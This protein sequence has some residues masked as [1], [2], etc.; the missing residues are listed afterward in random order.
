MPI[1]KTA[2]L[3]GATSKSIAVRLPL[4]LV[5]AIDAACQEHGI[6]PSEF[7]RGVVSQWVYGTTQLSGPDEG[8][9]QARSMA[10]QIA[11]VMMRKVHDALGEAIRELPAD[12]A[13]A[14]EM[15]QGFHARK[16]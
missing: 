11:H 13:G 8:Y 7:I 5:A 2:A 14:V 10:T 6:T 1:Q 12:H 3:K 16:G 15:L 9:A 4:D